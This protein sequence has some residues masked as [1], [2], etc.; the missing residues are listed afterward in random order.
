V[1][2][3]IAAPV[4]IALAAG[5]IVGYGLA[6]LGVVWFGPSPTLEISAIHRA[7]ASVAASALLAIPFVTGIAAAAGDRALDRRSRRTARWIAPGMLLAALG[8]LAVAAFR[9]LDRNGGIRTFGVE[10][11]GGDL[12]SMGF[13]MFLLL[14]VTALAG[15]LVA[16]ST[17]RL[18]LTGRRFGRAARL[19]WRRV[20]LEPAPVAAVVVAVALATGCLTTSRALADA[21]RRQLAEKADVYVGSDLAVTVYDEPA[22]LEALAGRATVLHHTNAKSGEMR[23]DLVGIDPTTFAGVARLRSDASPHTLTTLVDKLR[24]DTGTVPAAIAVGTDDEIGAVVQVTPIGSKT[25]VE[26][27]VVESLTFFPT[28]SSGAA[29][30]V[31]ARPVVDAAVA[32]PVATLLARDPPPDVSE[33][34]NRAGVRTGLIRRA[35]TAFDGSAYSALRWAYGPLAVLGILFAFL[36]VAFQLL[37]IAARA[38][39]RRAAHVVMRRQGFTTRALYL[40]ATIETAAPLLA[41]VGVGALASLAAGTLAVPRLDPMP[42]LQPPATFTY[43]WQTLTVVAVLAPIWALV[44]AGLITRST[45][46]A[47]PMEVMHGEL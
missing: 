34:L 42:S 10:S 17:P 18:R 44:V 14:A 23:V 25:E 26:L 29:M 39:A 21:S 8:A 22:G 45:V 11:R 13:A 36:A 1:A 4:G 27:R 38:T 46:A 6:Y 20:V 33:R 15:V 43:P 19:G 28:K 2:L 9:H 30:Y 5:S 35:S 32:F 24:P 12:L 3:G 31:V 41:G 40:A 16:A 47:D 7:T 37:I